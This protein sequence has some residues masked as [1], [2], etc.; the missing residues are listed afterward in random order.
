MNPC[1]GSTGWGWG[2]VTRD[3]IKSVVSSGLWPGNEALLFVD[4]FFRQCECES[5][6]TAHQVYDHMADHGEASLDSRDQEIDVPGQDD[7]CI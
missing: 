7:A 6:Q 1:P 5:V 4:R 3:A 2:G